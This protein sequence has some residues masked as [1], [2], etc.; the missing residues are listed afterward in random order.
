M[1]YEKMYSTFYIC[2]YTHWKPGLT[3]VGLT[4]DAGS[5]AH[6]DKAVVYIF[7]RGDSCQ[8]CFPTHFVDAF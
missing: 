2:G 1:K 8:A 6:N 5:N 4:W 3:F 7:A